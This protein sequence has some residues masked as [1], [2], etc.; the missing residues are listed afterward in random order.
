MR[1]PLIFKKCNQSWST[2]T[3]SQLFKR[4]KPDLSLW[5]ISK[6]MKSWW[7]LP[8]ILN[9]KIKKNIFNSQYSVLL[10]F[11][12]PIF[13]DFHIIFLLKIIKRNLENLLFIPTVG[14]QYTITYGNYRTNLKFWHANQ[15]DDLIINEHVSLVKLF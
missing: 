3:S 1:F 9:K 2:S 15:I 6:K 8:K 7:Y 5:L 4:H 11:R 13:R 12:H 14:I 10:I